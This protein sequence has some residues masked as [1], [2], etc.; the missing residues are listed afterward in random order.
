MLLILSKMVIQ[1]Y[2]NLISWSE[3]LVLL[4]IIDQQSCEDVTKLGTVTSNEN[5]TLMLDYAVFRFKH[6]TS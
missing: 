2:K 4:S 6:Q 1:F 5:W 3:K